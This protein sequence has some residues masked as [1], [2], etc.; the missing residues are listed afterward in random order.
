MTN[1]RTSR[2]DDLT[3][4]EIMALLGAAGPL[5]RQQLAA[6]LGLGI[7]TVHE[8]V[9]RLLSLGFLE[10][11]GPQADG[12]GRPRIPLRVVPEA[13]ATLGVRIAADHLVAVVVALDG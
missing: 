12:V 1:R 2:R 6:R 5:D 9:A 10:V 11:L 3:R 4:V 7:A 8:H 13:A